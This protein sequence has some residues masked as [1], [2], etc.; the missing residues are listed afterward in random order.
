MWGLKMIWVW[1][2]SLCEAW[3]GVAWCVVTLSPVAS[4]WSLPC[5]ASLSV[6]GQVSSMAAPSPASSTECQNCV[7]YNTVLLQN[8]W[9]GHGRERIFLFVMTQSSRMIL[10]SLLTVLLIFCKLCLGDSG[11]Y[12]HYRYNTLPAPSKL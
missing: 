3:V 4:R 8:C 11:N 5:P 10:D 2:V 7:E 1:N 6:S 9:H 12:K